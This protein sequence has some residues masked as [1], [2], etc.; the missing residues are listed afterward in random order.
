MGFHSNTEKKSGS[1]AKDRLKLLLVSERLNCSPG[2]LI[3][4]KNEMIQAAE[5]YVSVDEKRDYI[6]YSQSPDAIIAKL[7]L[8]QHSLRKRTVNTNA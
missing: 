5:K 7:P 2:M 3:M 4:L 1:I 8:Q 6:T